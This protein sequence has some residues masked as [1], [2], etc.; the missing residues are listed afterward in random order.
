MKNDG[1]W[2]AANVQLQNVTANVSKEVVLFNYLT[3]NKSNTQQSANN[4]SIIIKRNQRITLFQKAN[5]ARHN[6]ERKI[7]GTNTSVV[8]LRLTIA[9]L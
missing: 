3:E 7:T 1:Y 5:G 8:R 9:L 4:S 2:D 6:V